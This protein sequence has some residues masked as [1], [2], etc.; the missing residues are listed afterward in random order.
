MSITLGTYNVHYFPDDL[1]SSVEFIK[2]RNVDILGLQ[3][4]KFYP[5]GKTSNQKQKQPRISFEYFTYQL[6]Q[7]YPFMICFN[8]PQHRPYVGDWYSDEDLCGNVIISKHEIVDHEIF[9]FTNGVHLQNNYDTGI[10]NSN[11]CQIS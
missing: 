2:E 11:T 9:S 3:E 6:Q 1:W 4:V 5:S 7:T 8:K 10:F